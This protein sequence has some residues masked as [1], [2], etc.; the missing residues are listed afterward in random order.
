[1]ADI[2]EMTNEI[3]EMFNKHEITRVQSIFV[4]KSVEMQINDNIIAD[5]IEELKK[6]NINSSAGIG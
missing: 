2:V 5:K 3:L 1:M 4:L 6:G